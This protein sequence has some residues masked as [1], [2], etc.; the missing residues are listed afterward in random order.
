MKYKQRKELDI[1]YYDD[2][3]KF[4]SSWIQIIKKNKP[5]ITEGVFYIH[6]IKTSDNIFNE[7]LDL[8]LKNLKI[9]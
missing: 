2:S 5:N 7:K 9:R 3:N 1:S 4:Q 8:S 6:L